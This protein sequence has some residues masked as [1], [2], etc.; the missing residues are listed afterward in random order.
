MGS[1][2]RSSP[3]GSSS[4][5]MEG[6]LAAVKRGSCLSNGLALFAACAE[7][8]STKASARMAMQAV[9]TISEDDIDKAFLYTKSPEWNG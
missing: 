4:G 2:A 8:G 1:L 6:T 9:T 7:D 3:T 5:A